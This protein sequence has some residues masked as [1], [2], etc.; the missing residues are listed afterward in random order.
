MARSEAV[1]TRGS[2]ATRALDRR[3]ALARPVGG[4]SVDLPVRPWWIA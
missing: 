2:A 1:D 4:G 3:G